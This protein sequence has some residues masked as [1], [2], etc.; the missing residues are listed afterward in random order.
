MAKETGRIKLP[1]H[2]TRITT[3]VYIRSM[4]EHTNI[5]MDKDLKKSLTKE[6]EAVKRS[7]TNYVE[8]LLSTH[9]DRKPCKR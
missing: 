3:I 7:F 9:Q 5:R 1:E 6:A 8:F 2:L 4:K